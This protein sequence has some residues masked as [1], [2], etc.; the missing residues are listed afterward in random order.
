MKPMLPIA[1]LTGM[2]LLLEACQPSTS[3]SGRLYAPGQRWVLTVRNAIIED[4]V[5]GSETAMVSMTSDGKTEREVVERVETKR[6]SDLIWK[7]LNLMSI[8]NQFLM[9][10]C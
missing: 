10:M 7:T 4:G 3:P 6:S 9:E 5:G 1:V 8:S 2:C